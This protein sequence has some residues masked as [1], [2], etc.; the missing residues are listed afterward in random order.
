MTGVENNNSNQQNNIPRPSI[1][2]L[3]GDLMSAVN[4]KNYSSNIVKIATNARVSAEDGQGESNFKGGDK[5]LL[6]KLLFIAGGV[7]VFIVVVVI[8]ILYGGMIGG[9]KEEGI[10][11]TEA[12]GTSTSTPQTIQRKTLIEAEAI[13]Q[14][15]L[16][17]SDKTESVEKIKNIQNQL[18]DR[19]INEKTTV[20]IDT[21]LGIADFFLKNRFS[22][23]DAL[24]TSLTNSYTFG[25]FN[26]SNDIFE[27]FIL[28]KVDS[29][30]STF[31]SMLTWEPYIRYDLQDMFKDYTAS[32]TSSNVFSENA[33]FKDKVLRNTDT[34]IDSDQDGTVHFVYG[35]INKE[36]LLIT[37]GEESFVSIRDRL[38]NNSTLR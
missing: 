3:E 35:F 26:N 27:T 22:G 33:S 5:N 8:F 30:D 28:I 10:T 13:L 38:L 34:R 21:K 16:S 1:H 32:S 18:R 9:T 25:L 29:F 2:T 31:A 37:G 17:N 19:N 36:Y 12:G 11:G 7:G 14:I 20:E 15:D 4:D 23:N 24:L 6:K